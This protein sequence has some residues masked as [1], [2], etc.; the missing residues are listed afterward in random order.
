MELESG[1]ELRAWVSVFFIPQPRPEAPSPASRPQTREARNW[2]F[3][4]LEATDRRDARSA[5]RVPDRPGL[6][7]A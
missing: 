7:R 3:R 6:P 1:L 5:L 2:R 4:R